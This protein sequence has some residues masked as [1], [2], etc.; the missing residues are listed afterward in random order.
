[1]PNRRSSKTEVLRVRPETEGSVQNKSPRVALSRDIL[2]IGMGEG[3]L[4]SDQF[5]KCKSK[6]AN[7]I[8]ED[9]VYSQNVC[10]GARGVV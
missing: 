5:V 8:L 10:L 4:Q 2:G 3:F 1:M 9:I 7:N 6:Q